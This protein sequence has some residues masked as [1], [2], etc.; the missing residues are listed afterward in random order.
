M[1]DPIRR[2]NV[3]LFGVLILIALW[4]SA[5][6]TLAQT[7]SAQTRLLRTPTVSASQIAFAYANNIWTVPRGGGSARR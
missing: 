3:H 4:L 7:S 2:R 5:P 6:S 1:I